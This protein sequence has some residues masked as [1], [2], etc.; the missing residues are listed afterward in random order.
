MYVLNFV[1]DTNAFSTENT[2]IRIKYENLTFH[3]FGFIV[4]MAFKA[5][6]RSPIGEGHILKGTLPSTVANG[7][8]KGVVKKQELEVG[9]AGLMDLR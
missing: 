3:I 2:T 9:L 8:I 1:A 6:V 5:G 4:P 7:A